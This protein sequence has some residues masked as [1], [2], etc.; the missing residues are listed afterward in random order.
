M[1]WT[2][3]IWSEQHNDL[4]DAL[5]HDFPRHPQLF[6]IEELSWFFGCSRE[7]MDRWC[8]ER[9]VSYIYGPGGP[10]ITRNNVFRLVD[11]FNI[12]KRGKKSKNVAV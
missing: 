12:E 9:G 5:D 10:R 1:P 3:D 4:C 7:T 11:Y 6:K 2:A 8:K